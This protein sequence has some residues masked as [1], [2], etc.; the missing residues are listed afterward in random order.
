[1]PDEWSITELFNRDYLHFSAQ[2]LTDQAS[3]DDVETIWRVLAPVDG[4]EVLDLGCGHGRIANR[5][6]RRGLRVTGLDATPVFLERA[7]HDAD[8]LG[9][10][11]EYVEG[12]MRAI[13]WADQ[14]DV[15][16]CWFTSFGYFDDEQN[17]IVLAGAH[18]ALR[19]GGRLLV[20]LNHK[21]GLLPRFLPATVQELEGDIQIE[22]HEYEPLTSR[23]NRWRVMIRDGKI[24][25]AFFFTRL[26]SFTEL[27][28]WLLQAGFQAVE[29]YAGDGGPLTASAPRMILV[30]TKARS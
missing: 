18:R 9:V 1:M 3:D 5:L 13:P 23:A 4:A 11:V 6:A 24:R 8:R 16:V 20:E 29:G 25:R 21:D 7:R 12:D 2:R 28:D 22:T 14:F 19:P 30:A 15:V 27:R 10:S 17:R 26:F